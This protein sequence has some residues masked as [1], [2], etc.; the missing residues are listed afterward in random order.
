MWLIYIY[1]L[2]LCFRL[3]FWL[4]MLQLIKRL[5]R[6][7]AHVPHSRRAR[8]DENT[9]YIVD[10][11]NY[12]GGSRI[13]G[14]GVSRIKCQATFFKDFVIIVTVFLVLHLLAKKKKK[15]GS[16]GCIL[17]N[18]KHI[19][20]LINFYLHQQELSNFGKLVL[21]ASVSTDLPWHIIRYGSLC[22]Y[23]FWYWWQTTVS[24][25]VVL[26]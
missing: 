3:P 20:Y 23:Q 9:K 15:A 5:H 22:S 7:H 10:N 14:W 25:E 1:T 6:T 4:I 16:F 18:S 11:K 13:S 12:R 17:S 8:Y 26:T 2:P 21:H 19:L 24:G